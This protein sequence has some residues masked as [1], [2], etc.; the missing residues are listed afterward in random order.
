MEHHRAVNV[1]GKEHHIF[2][3][4][5][6]VVRWLYVNQENKTHSLERLPFPAAALLYKEAF[7]KCT[8]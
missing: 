3:S 2:L 5:V 7:T 6:I 4:S 1:C 8:S